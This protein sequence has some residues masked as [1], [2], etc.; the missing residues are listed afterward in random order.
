MAQGHR[1]A[2]R[3]VIVVVVLG[4]LAAAVA[5]P[6]RAGTYTF[7]FQESIV[8]DRLV[9]PAVHGTFAAVRDTSVAV[10]GWHGPRVR[11]TAGGHT[12]G[13]FAMLDL[14]APSPAKF[15]QS[16]I[17]VRYRGCSKEANAGFWMEAS[18]LVGQSEALGTRRTLPPFDA[19][20][21][22]AAEHPGSATIARPDRVRFKLGS[23]KTDA[24]HVAGTS[25]LIN[26]ISGT[27]EDVTVPMVTAMAATGTTTGAVR[28][29]SWSAADGQA[30]PRSVTLRVTGPN[31]FVL[32]P[33]GWTGTAA[34]NR[35]CLSGQFMSGCQTAVSGAASITLPAVTGTYTAAATVTDGAGNVAVRTLDLARV[36]A[37]TVLSAPS[38]GGVAQVG[39][40]LTIA[41]G[42]FG[43]VPTA[44]SYSFYRLAG[45]VL[46]PVQPAGTRPSYVVGRADHGSTIVGRVT[47]SNGAGAALVDTPAS[48]IVLPG[49][50]SGGV[51]SVDGLPAVVDRQLAIVPGT[52][53]N[54]G[55][56]GNPVVTAVR[57]Y[58]CAAACALVGHATT[59]LPTAADVGR[60][61]VAEVDVA[62]AAGA[63]T[64][65]TA[66]T[67]V[68]V[69][70][71]PTIVTAPAVAGQARVGETLAALPPVVAGH[72][73]ALAVALT[74]FLCRD[75]ALQTCT[76]EAGPGT[77]HLIAET[78]RGLRLRV[79][80]DVTGAGGSIVA[81]SP[82]TE[83]VLGRN[84][85]LLVAP[86]TITAC[87]GASS[88]I[89][90]EASLDRLR[91][92]A[93]QPVVVR[94]RV[95]VAGDVARPDRITVVR[96]G[97]ALPA[98]VDVSGGFALTFVPAL[99]ERVTVSLTVAGRGD[100]LVLD[101]G[102][103][104]VVPRIT[105]R[106]TVR[107]DRG[108]AVRDLRVTGRVQPRV[109]ISKFRLLLE[110]RTPKGRVVGLICRVDEQPIVRAGRYAAHCR[111]RGLPRLARYRVRF[112][113]GPGSP[114]EAAQTGWQRAG[115]R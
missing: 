113:P 84:E 54:G 69:A 78:E 12:A 63:A 90:L 40:T 38:L 20:T 10:A 30:G 44:I 61:L 115:L 59:Y 46:T 57:W 19:C 70:G 15:V 32:A 31:G 85:C 50:P 37:P 75:F 95:T 39:Q 24:S 80:A 74:W 109:P 49:L 89:T 7:S 56:P 28:V 65:A 83:P 112:L 93:G 88:R 72:G 68:V 48:A 55:A 58:S 98:A 36:A 34:A 23:T 2:L 14:I 104:R 66:R 71:P 94:G 9:G 52:W 105:A 11:T 43:N 96:G 103:V 16:S 3:F 97:R 87:V 67:A 102:E 8:D 5:A 22:V 45:G 107:R 76:V 81:W 101:A 33:A 27:I 91:A 77:A 26:Q 42:A 60:G 6:A 92:T 4:A 108:G 64:G 25:V 41:G 18:V 110:G 73:A 86:G 13:S 62:N 51:P 114:L 17:V 47:G 106:F 82:P 111:S 79:R 21:E 100:A 35:G 53:D 29:V 1:W 99:S